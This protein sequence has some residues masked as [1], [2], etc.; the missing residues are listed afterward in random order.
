MLISISGEVEVLAPLSEDKTPVLRALDA[1]DPWSTTALHDALIVS[2]DLLEGEKGRR[3]IVVLSDGQDRY[4]RA[5]EVDVL[6]RARKSDVM[7]YPIAIGRRR[8]PWFAELA[9][10]SG[11]RSFHVREPR[12]LTPTL[13][14]IAEE[15]RTQYLLGY[16]PTT[17][18]TSNADDWRSIVVKVKRQGLR[19]RARSGYLAK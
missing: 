3:A 7:I 4:S 19:V 12:E 6:N 16:E 18:T 9:A 11:G 17:A 15:L 5:R 10:I 8:A 13:Q 14:A 2:L 1:V